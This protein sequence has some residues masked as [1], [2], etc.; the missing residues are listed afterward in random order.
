M[1]VHYIMIKMFRTTGRIAVT[2]RPILMKRKDMP[3]KTRRPVTSP[4]KE[5]QGACGAY[6]AEKTIC[7]NKDCKLRKKA[8]GC[9]GF[10]GCPG[11]K[12]G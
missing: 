11:F 3:K 8:G 9:F 6:G 2:E 5:S 1:A 4:D 7:L 12:P 10:E